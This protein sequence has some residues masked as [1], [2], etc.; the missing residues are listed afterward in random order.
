[1]GGS[2]PTSGPFLRKARAAG[3]TAPFF[4]G[5]GSKTDD[6]FRLA[7]AA[8][9]GAYL[10][11]SGVP[12]ENL[13]SAQDFLSRLQGSLPGGRRRA[14]DFRRLRLRGGSH[15][16]EV[17][18]SKRGPTGPS[19]WRLS[20]TNTHSTMLG[21]V[22]FDSKGDLVKGLITMTKADFKNKTFESV[23]YER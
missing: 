13:P 17:A 12:V 18:A 2:T 3:V 20:R 11:V 23:I 9:E 8:V 4:S 19:C 7:G 1:M 14:P 10:T 22:A 16:P 6:L 21:D 15:R 5:D